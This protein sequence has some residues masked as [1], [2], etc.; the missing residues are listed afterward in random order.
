MDSHQIQGLA[1]PLPP[2]ER[3]LW[4][5]APRWT[6]LAIHAFHVR[7]LV[8]Y[9]TL[10]L[11]LRA[12]GVLADGGTA[13]EAAIAALWLLPVATAAIALVTLIAWLTAR[14]TIYAI[15]SKRVVM[16]I[17]V[18]LAITLNLPFRLVEAAG[19]HMHADGTADLPLQLQEGEHLAWLHLWP[20]VRPWRTAHPE[21]MFRA[22]ADPERVAAVL[23][24]ALAEHAGVA[25]RHAPES[26]PD[27]LPPRA[28]PGRL[29]ASHR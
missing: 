2:G 5:G 20:H 17:G 23:A 15:T 8:L 6:S 1:E 12:I 4:Q 16:R 10:I 22:V 26:M 3:V 14:T 11:G 25:V 21:P 13:G 24:R 27:A 19:L 29:A 9:F 18:V 7:K 28:A